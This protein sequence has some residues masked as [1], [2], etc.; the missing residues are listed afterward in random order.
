MKK[1]FEKIRMYLMHSVENNLEELKV[2]QGK[3]LMYIQNQRTV[4]NI[5]DA[6]FK[7]FSQW[8][9]DGIIQWIISKIPFI[10]PT[11]IEF[12]VEDYLESNTRFLLM[13]NNWKGLVIDGSYKNIE[14]IRKSSLFW[15]YNLTA[16][17]SF[18]TRDNINNIFRDNDFQGEI[19]ILSID[20]DGNDYWVWDA[21]ETIVPKVVICEYNSIFGP[22]KRVTIP[23]EED[24]VRSRAHYSHLYYGA[25]LASLVALGRQKGYICVGGNS[26]GNNVFFVHKSLES[27]FEEVPCEVAY[28]E[29]KF[30]ES[31]DNNG[32]LSFL[33]G[34]ERLKAIRDMPLLDIDRGDI[35][36]I[37]EVYGLYQESSDA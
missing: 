13:N 22:Q 5:H 7:V 3:Q 35:L 19:G 15:R 30:R 24:F 33:S 8:G 27:F 12:G 10:P 4:S 34:K 2:L 36:P 20:I 14:K 9:E 1:I 18:V 25:S 37:S 26:A 32:R 11:F 23:Y 31:R 28:T 16:L 17:C 21:I 6:E 29:S